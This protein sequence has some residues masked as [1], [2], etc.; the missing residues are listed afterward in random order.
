MIA[1]EGCVCVGG[2]AIAEGLRGTERKNRK[3][4][5]KCVRGIYIEGKWNLL[6]GENWR[7]ENGELR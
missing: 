7:V 6:R 4:A 1:L 3:K 5:E 2:G